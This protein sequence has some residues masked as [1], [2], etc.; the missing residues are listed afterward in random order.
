M[1]FFFRIWE[2]HKSFLTTTAFDKLKRDYFLNFSFSSQILYLDEFK[3]IS[4]G[5]SI[6]DLHSGTK[7]LEC[8]KVAASTQLHVQRRSVQGQWPSD[9]WV[10]PVDAPRI[11][12]RSSV[13]VLFPRHVCSRTHKLQGVIPRVSVWFFL[14][15]SFC[16]SLFPAASIFLLHK[17]AQ[18]PVLGAR[19]SSY[20]FYLLPH[21]LHLRDLSLFVDNTYGSLWC[22]LHRYNA[23]VYVR[24][25]IVCQLVHSWDFLKGKVDAASH[26]N[27]RELLSCLPYPMYLPRLLFLPIRR[28]CF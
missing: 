25:G 26:L 28:F 16:S 4:Q 27:V 15:L 22:T 7:S 19:C 12:E 9:Q 18:L 20:P 17:A 3:F 8:A 5:G 10:P 11:T 13:L 24:R 23:F 14:F 6:I 2:F 1:F 21:K